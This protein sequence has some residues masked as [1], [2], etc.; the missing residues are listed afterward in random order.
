M[1]PKIFF[2][3]SSLHDFLWAHRLSLLLEGFWILDVDVQIKTKK[4]YR[5]DL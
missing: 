3:F 5:T 2:L 4:Q 1:V